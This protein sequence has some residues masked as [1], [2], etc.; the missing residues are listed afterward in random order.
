LVGAKKTGLLSTLRLLA[1]DNT[2]SGLSPEMIATLIPDATISRIVYAT[3]FCNSSSI[4]V[5]HKTSNSISIL[6]SSSSSRFVY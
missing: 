2:V 4:P 5:A 3:S 1:I 6:Y